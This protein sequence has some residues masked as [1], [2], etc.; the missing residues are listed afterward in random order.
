[1]VEIADYLNMENSGNNI[2]AKFKQG[3]TMFSVEFFPPKTED[4]ARQILRTAN[5]LKDISPDFVS[6]TYGAGGSSRE[7]TLEYG[8]L[9][10]EIFN[11]EVMPHLA[12]YG[13]SKDEIFSILKRFENSGF[14]NVMALRGDK[15]KDNATLA[16]HPD[17]FAHADELVAF[18]R[19]NFP[20]F[21]IGCA[22]YP[23]KH[24]EAPDFKTDIQNLKRKVDAGA[25]FITTQL[26]FDNAHYFRFAEECAKVGI[27]KPIVAGILPALSF[28]QVL[29][30][31]N[32][33][34]TDIPQELLNKLENVSD[35]SES[36]K[37]GLEWAQKQIEELIANN[38]PAI[39]LY[40]LNRSE[41]AL[42]LVSSFSSR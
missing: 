35:S 25:D 21:G 40:I 32:M 3:R 6:I 19:E 11:F 9:L 13:H 20:S 12:C 17:G 16:P 24:P 42:K 39:H 29:N 26:F 18:I 8:E 4:G 41:S 31:K 38:V 2:S 34:A 28:K 37:I 14:R 36:A 33:C 22:G 10:R 23:E 30:F 7:R 27:N 5:K 1:M 15:P